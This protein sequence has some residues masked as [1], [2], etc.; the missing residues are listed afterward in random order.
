M[1][2]VSALFGAVTG[3]VKSGPRSRRTRREN[4]DFD[5]LVVSVTK[6]SRSRS[7]ARRWQCN[8]LEFVIAPSRFVRLQEGFKIA[9]LSCRERRPQLRHR[10]QIL[11]ADRDAAKAFQRR[12]GDLFE[13]YPDRRSAT[14]LQLPQ[15]ATMQFLR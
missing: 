2:G 8:P 15:D 12:S 13:V 3:G 4:P 5:Q 1:A 11:D 9:D 14:P 7:Q 10:V 6:D